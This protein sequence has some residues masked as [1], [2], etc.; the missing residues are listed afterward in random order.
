MRSSLYLLVPLFLLPAMA[1]G[2]AASPAEHLA[3]GSIRL[4]PGYEWQQGRGADSAVG[5]ITRRGGLTIYYDIGG[6]AG[7]QVDARKRAKD[8]RWSKDQVVGGSPVQILV[9]KDRWLVVTFP[10]DHANFNC[11]LKSDEELTDALLMVL[12]YRPAKT[13]R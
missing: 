3:L 6:M 1:A 9:S 11:Q 13:R 5:K 2:Y 8:F 12:T 10:D 7:N 4:L